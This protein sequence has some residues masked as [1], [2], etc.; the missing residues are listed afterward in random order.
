[1]QIATQYLTGIHTDTSCVS[2]IARPSETPGGRSDFRTLTES[3]N[4]MERTENRDGREVAK[5]APS[6]K[7][8][9]PKRKKSCSIENRP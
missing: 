7:E 1:M 3:G 4:R 2:R 6:K 5:F 8:F 9:F